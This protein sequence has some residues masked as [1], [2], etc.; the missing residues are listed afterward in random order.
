M[1]AHILAVFL[2]IFGP[3]CAPAAPPHLYTVTDWQRD[4]AAK[5][6]CQC[7]TLKVSPEGN[8]IGSARPCGCGE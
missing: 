6:V 5:Q 7:L 4:I 1:L 8:V 2:R 3:D